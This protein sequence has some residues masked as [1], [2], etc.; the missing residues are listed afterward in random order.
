MFSLKDRKFSINR[1]TGVPKLRRFSMGEPSANGED[2][3]KFFFFLWSSG[4]TNLF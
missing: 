1:N 2:A 4:V 3:K